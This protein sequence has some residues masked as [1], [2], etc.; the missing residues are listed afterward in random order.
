MVALTRKKSIPS[1]IVAHEIAHMLGASVAFLGD[2]HSTLRHFC[3]H[4]RY[5]DTSVYLGFDAEAVSG[6]F[7]V[8]VN[9]HST[10]NGPISDDSIDAVR[11]SSSLAPIGLASDKMRIL[12]SLKSAKHV[13]DLLADF[14][15]VLSVEDRMHAAKGKLTIDQ[16]EQLCGV[17]AYEA[18]A[19]IAPARLKGIEDLYQRYQGFDGTLPLRSFI[20]RD[21]ANDILEESLKMSKILFSIVQV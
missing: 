7:A 16:H 4:P 21:L 8:L 15:D 19:K 18:C 5:H 6:E 9:K 10:V 12:R 2:D 20:P 13:F 11:R 17:F 14:G 1:D 3:Q